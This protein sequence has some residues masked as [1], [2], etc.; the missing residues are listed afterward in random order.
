MLLIL[1]LRLELVLVWLLVRRLRLA[2]LSLVSATGE[3]AAIWTTVR[4]LNLGTDIFICG[5]AARE[6][7]VREVGRCGRKYT[8]VCRRIV[9]IIVIAAASAHSSKV[10]V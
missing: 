4:A 5:L 3:V 2:V 9:P 8:L 10:E 6:D 1:R 7:G